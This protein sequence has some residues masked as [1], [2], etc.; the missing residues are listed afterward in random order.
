MVNFFLALQ[1]YISPYIYKANFY[2]IMKIFYSI[3]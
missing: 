1:I 2:S 3:L